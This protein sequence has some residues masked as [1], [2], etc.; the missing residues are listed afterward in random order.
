M[1]MYPKCGEASANESDLKNFSN[2]SA[3][4]T[5]ATIS[6]GSNF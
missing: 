4:L 3:P 6:D 2:L 5:H 1:E